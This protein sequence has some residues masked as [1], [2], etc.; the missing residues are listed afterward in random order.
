MQVRPYGI[1][2]ELDDVFKFFL[3][4]ISGRYWW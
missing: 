4:D 3:T 2:I 1:R